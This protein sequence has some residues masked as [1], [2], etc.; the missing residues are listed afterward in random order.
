MLDGARVVVTMPGKNV[1]STL[2]RRGF[3]PLT[4]SHNRIARQSY[5]FPHLP[6]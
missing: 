5:I 1:A 4:A 6:I 3:A 2:A